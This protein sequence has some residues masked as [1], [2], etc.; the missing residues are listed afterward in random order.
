MLKIQN[1]TI[2]FN[3]NKAIDNFS[4]NIESGK[5]LGIVGESGSGKSMTALS[6]I[7]LLP[8]NANVSGSIL[9]GKNQENDLLKL[10]DKEMQNIRGNRISMIFQD[11]L[12]AFNPSQ[13]IGKQLSN[14]I[15]IH[16]SLKKDKRKELI[17]NLF[18]SVK[19]PAERVYKS[20]PFQLSGGQRQRALI[21]MS[22][23]N[24]PTLLIADEPTTALDV[25]VQKEIVD[26][27]KTLTKERN[28]TMVFISHD[29]ALVSQ[30]ADYIAVLYK[31]VC[32]EQGNVKE[33]IS[34]PKNDYTKALLLCK[35]SIETEKTRLPEVSDIM[36]N[37][38]FQKPI[39]VQ[40]P[41]NIYLSQLIKVEN[42]IVDYPVNQ[43]REKV[44]AINNISFEIFEGETLGLVGESGCGK[45]TLSRTLLNL[46]KTTQGSIIFKGSP[47]SLIAKNRLFWSKKVQ[48]VFQDP[49]SSLNPVY[50]VGECLSETFRIHFPQ[51]TSKEIRNCVIQLLEKVGLDSN[52]FNRLPSELS[53]G[54]RQ[55]VVIARALIPNPELLIC[56]EAVSA[57]DVS[58]QSRILNLL[59]D[60]KNE[61]KLT[62]LFISHDLAVVKYMSDRLLVMQNGIIVESGNP[63]SIYKTP[64][65]EY[66]AKLIGSIC[67]FC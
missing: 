32:V 27:L 65:N 18:N 55:R 42:M 24:N 66:T 48:I 61:L 34:N 54:Q 60:L 7:G 51:K 44:R 12:S 63:D 47:I 35:P 2:D 40:K 22:L 39:E 25:T 56:D 8:E 43:G 20:Y 46:I 31:G 3:G 19:L 38:S 29:L 59:N 6:I 30:I 45:T 26:L 23:A 21:A 58:V 57:L 10:T 17:L 15:K 13:T 33:V 4:I 41:I 64:K 62:Y 52:Y 11:P 67:D 1:L 9:F 28:L 16:Q 49:Y 14:T 37:K 53:G 36:E 5:I 50:R